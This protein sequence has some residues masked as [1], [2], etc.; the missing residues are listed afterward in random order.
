MWHVTCDIWHVT[1]Y[2][3]HVTYDDFFFLQKGPNKKSQKGPE[4][5]INS[6]KSAQKCRKVLKSFISLYWCYYPHTL[7][8]SV[9]HV[10][11]IF[12]WYWWYYSHWSND[13]VSPVHGIFLLELKCTMFTLAQSLKTIDWR[14]KFKT[15]SFQTVNKIKSKFNI[16]ELVK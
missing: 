5:Q 8:E 4:I 11:A 6:L 7:R 15:M 13:L 2:L 10:S 9:T 16:T 14:P 3:L 12:F 1:F